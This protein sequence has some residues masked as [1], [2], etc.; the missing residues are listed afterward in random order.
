MRLYLFAF[1]FYI[2][3]VCSFVGGSFAAGTNNWKLKAEQTGF[4]ET[5]TYEEVERICFQLARD[6]SSAVR[7]Q[8]I[9]QT[10]EGRNIYSIIAS[11]TGALDP[12]TAKNKNIPVVLM[13]AGTHSGEIDGKDAGLILLREWLSTH[14]KNP[15]NELIIAWIP[16][17]NVDG[18]EDRGRFNRPN[19]NGPLEQ[20]ARTTAQRIN[21]NRDWIL[22]QSTEVRSVLRWMNRWDPLAII[23]LHVTDGLKFR[24]KVSITLSTEYSVNQTLKNKTA[25]LHQHILNEVTQ[26]GHLPLGFYPQLRDVDNP[27]AGFLLEADAPR[28]SHVYAVLRNRIGLLIENYAWNDYATRIQTSKDTISAIAKSIAKQK[29]QLMQATRLAD[30]QINQWSGAHVGMVW[31]NS[32]EL[33]TQLMPKF[34]ELQGYR[35]QVHNDAPVVGGRNIT[36]DE[37]VPEVWRVPFFNEMRAVPESMVNLP[38]GGYV[39]PAAWAGLVKPYLIQHGIKFKTLTSSKKSLQL[40]ALRVQ[41][42]DVVYDTESFQ[43][44]LRTNITG[45]WQVESIDLY[46]GALFVPIRQ[47][48]ALLLAHLLEPFAPDSLSSWGLFNTAY[49]VSDYMANHR[50]LELI[51]WMYEKNPKIKDT[52]GQELFDRLDDIKQSYE[53]RMLADENFKKDSQARIDF[54]LSYL[55]AF[56]TKLNLYPIYRSAYQL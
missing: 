27:G 3:F 30:Q 54:W 13:I 26:L 47:S 9:G 5:G 15:L 34:L 22:G 51:R 42:N 31:A 52:Y 41:P 14:Q 10:S 18:H 53:K 40:E 28:F 55:P 11:R 38:H 4:K 50:E 45:V 49:E 56:D 39:I 20:G 8:S 17:L 12:G 29:Q 24:H 33:N 48:K 43:G 46:K 25:E 44:R 37:T 35:Y 19:Q 1:Y 6:F 16:V 7:C 36:Y 32:L 23:D 21:I 2:T